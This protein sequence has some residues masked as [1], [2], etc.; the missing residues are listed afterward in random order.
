MAPFVCLATAKALGFLGLWCRQH[1][2]DNITHFLL[3]C[4]QTTPHQHN[5]KHSSAQL[6]E[7]MLVLQSSGIRSVSLWQ[8]AR[9]AQSSDEEVQALSVQRLVQ[10]IKKTQ[11]QPLS[12]SSLSL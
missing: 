11:T 10:K 3:L 6:S 12:P 1:E 2:G 5:L 8:S 9:V 7:L 4:P